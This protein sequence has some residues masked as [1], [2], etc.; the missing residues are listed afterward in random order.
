MVKKQEVVPDTIVVIDKIVGKYGEITLDGHS[1]LHGKARGGFNVGEELVLL[2]KPRKI[3][4][5]KL[6]RVKRCIDGDIG[7]MFYCDVYAC[8]T[9]K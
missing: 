4:G 7:E 5:V 2:S 8:C 1:F 3:D 6:V 9:V